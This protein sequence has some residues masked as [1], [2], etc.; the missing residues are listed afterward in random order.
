MSTILTVKLQED[1]AKALADLMLAQHRLLVVRALQLD[2]A[3]R[4]SALHRGDAMNAEKAFEDISD[5]IS[6][7]C[8]A[9]GLGEHGSELEKLDRVSSMLELLESSIQRPG[10]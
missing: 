6:D 4:E 3:A 10:A 8:S 9:R 2:E 5:R 7:L 1:A